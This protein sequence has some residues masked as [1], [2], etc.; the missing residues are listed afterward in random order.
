VRW[1][2]NICGVCVRHLALHGGLTRRGPRAQL[3]RW[4]HCP[5]SA[6]EP[7][8]RGRRAQ[9]PARPQKG[10]T[11]PDREAPRKP[12]TEDGG[13]VFLVVV[14][15]WPSSRLRR[16]A[17]APRCVRVSVEWSG[18]LGAGSSRPLLQCTLG[19]F[20]FSASLGGRF[21][22]FATPALCW[23]AS[24]WLER[25]YI[26]DGAARLTAVHLWRHLSFL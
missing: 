24:C 3:R 1:S 20:C 14:V 22:C 4:G 25:N 6:R 21:W 10:H 26:L 13:H 11:A 17:A 19:S 18:S 7:G 9:A 16:M 2:L 12:S 23:S 8:A 15:C 5:A